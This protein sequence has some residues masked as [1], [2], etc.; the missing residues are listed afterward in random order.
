MSGLAGVIP[1]GFDLAMSKIARLAD[2]D[3]GGADTLSVPLC[4]ASISDLGTVGAAVTHYGGYMNE[5]TARTEAVFSRL[6]AGTLTPA[7]LRT[8]GA[9][10][11]KTPGEGVPDAPTLEEIDQIKQAI[12]TEVDEGDGS[13]WRLLIGPERLNL[14][15]ALLWNPPIWQI[16]ASGLDQV[17][18]AAD[19]AG[20][21]DQQ[22]LDLS[23]YPM[24]AVLDALVAAERAARGI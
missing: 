18:V 8:L 15:P 4:A 1:V 7:H 5:L 13:A 19:L 14:R 24:G 3:A 20:R 9:S 21:T 6:V 11:G 22:I 10:V 17:A 23:G 12:A 16:V 2:S